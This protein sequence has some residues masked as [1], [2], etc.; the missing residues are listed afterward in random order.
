MSDYPAI[1]TVH[2]PTGPTNACVK[3]ARGV[4]KLFR[5]MGVHTNAT[6]A[7][8]GAQCDNCVNEHANDP[9]PKTSEAG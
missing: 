4:E 3:H 6:R 2:T 1:F 8:D 5:F 9:P 7:P